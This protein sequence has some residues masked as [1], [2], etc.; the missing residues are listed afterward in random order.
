MRA[1]LG[2]LMMAAVLF[3]ASPALAQQW[4]FEAEALYLQRDI[5]GGIVTSNN[6]S[7]ASF[8]GLTP[9]TTAL[10]T[11]NLD[12]DWE[13]GFR[14]TL[15]FHPDANN[16]WEAT[17]WGLHEWSD[18]ASAQPCANIGGF[19]TAC[20][21]LDAVFSQG[22]S[23]GSALP[24]I[25]SFNFASQ[26]E[27]KYETEIHNAEL[28]YWRHLSRWGNFHPSIL[29]GIRYIDLREEFKLSSIGGTVVIPL[30]GVA[31]SQGSG[32]YKI[33]T[34]NRLIG[35]QFG[36]QGVWRVNQRVGVGIRAKVGLLANFADQDSDLT[37][38]NLILAPGTTTLSKSESEEGFATVAEAGAFI[39]WNVWR[40]LSLRVG[41]DVFH[42]GG[43]ALAPEQFASSNTTDAFAQ[44]D[45]NG[46]A[47][48]HGPSGGVRIVW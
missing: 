11:E 35:I 43:V 21:F 27:I 15:G 9:N 26:H 5:P 40:N 30:I 31:L 16:S 36:G 44:L 2:V 42:M 8:A 39:T 28:N 25:N 37:N 4:S 34:Q 47:L 41:Y 7:L 33:E 14:A 20:A 46:S 17:Y 10:S 1:I 3:S 22:L 32:E 13:V 6:N 12:F 45:R 24:S 38:T 29:V 18:R 48:Y 19:F 23:L